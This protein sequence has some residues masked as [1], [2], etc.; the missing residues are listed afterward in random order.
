M[1]QGVEHQAVLKGV[2][3]AVGQGSQ[4]SGQPIPVVIP[5]PVGPKPV[6]RCLKLLYAG[7]SGPCSPFQPEDAVLLMGL[8]GSLSPTLDLGA[9]TLIERCFTDKNR[10]GLTGDRPL[11]QWIH[12]AL[13]PPV[14]LVQ[15][16]TSPHVVSTAEEKAR[17][18]QEFNAAI[19][20]ME[21]YSVLDFC[22][23]K[24]LRGAVLRVVG[25]RS[26]EDIPDV[27]PAIGPEGRIRSLALAGSFLRQPIAAARL[28]QGSLRGLGVLHLTAQHM[29]QAWIARHS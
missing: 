26:D 16:V 21:G 14:F 8:G 22:Q 17:L 19:V 29:T 18:R 11:L 23:A 15:G 20:D 5:I 13:I 3:R 9:V 12:Q 6:E 2:Q 7:S 10:G 4:A 25:D 27:S 24:G 1:P 28:V